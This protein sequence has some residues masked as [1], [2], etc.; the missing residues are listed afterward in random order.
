MDGV[1]VAVVGTE[2]IA[3]EV[4]TTV[5]SVRRHFTTAVVAV[6]E[7]LAVVA[8]AVVAYDRTEVAAVD[9]LRV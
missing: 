1:A 3:G 2:V 8:V 9:F 5:N 4:S 7:V 6:V